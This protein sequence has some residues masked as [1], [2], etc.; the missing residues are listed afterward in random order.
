MRGGVNGAVC[1]G[2]DGAVRMG[3]CGGEGGHAAACTRA[4][5]ASATAESWVPTLST[6]RPG[7]WMCVCVFDGPARYGVDG[8]VWMGRCGGEGVNGRVWR[9]GCEWSGVKGRVSMVGCRWSG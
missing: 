8:S 6:N 9:G 1:L 4:Y 5:G 2:V 7:M 3:R